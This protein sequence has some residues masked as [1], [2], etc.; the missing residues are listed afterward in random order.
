MK[1]KPIFAWYDFWIG[2]FWDSEKRRLYFFPIPCIGFV[3]GEWK[4]AK[5]LTNDQFGKL[6]WLALKVSRLSSWLTLLTLREGRVR[7]DEFRK[8]AHRKAMLKSLR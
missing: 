1:I 2:F 8:H 3:I 6:K 5:I 7:A 4:E